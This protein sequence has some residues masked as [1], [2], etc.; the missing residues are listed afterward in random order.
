M[1]CGDGGVV[2]GLAVVVVDG[3]VDGVPPANVGVSGASPPP[4]SSTV[5]V[6]GCVVVVVVV[7]VVGF[8]FLTRFLTIVGGSVSTSALALEKT[9]LDDEGDGD[10]GMIVSTS[11]VGSRDT[12][13]RRHRPGKSQFT[14]MESL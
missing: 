10:G 3:G 12:N 9:R 1:V 5:V 4:A 2:V 11:V 14:A 13:R 6:G 7:V 8:V